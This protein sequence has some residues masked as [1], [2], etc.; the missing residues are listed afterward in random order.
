MSFFSVITYHLPIIYYYCSYYFEVIL[1]LRLYY[2]YYY[3]Y[4]LPLQLL[5]SASHTLVYVYV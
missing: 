4:Y 1:V 3:Y 5:S 2:Y